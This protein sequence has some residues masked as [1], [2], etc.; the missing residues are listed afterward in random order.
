MLQEFIFIW[1]S[2]GANVII[3]AANDYLRSYSFDDGVDA[4]ISFYRFI[5]HIFQ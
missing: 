5:E 3:M 1:S 4:S 2:Y